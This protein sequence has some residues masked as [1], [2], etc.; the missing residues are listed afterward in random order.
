MN[1]DTYNLTNP[2]KSIWLTEEFFKGT[3][4][5][6]ISGNVLINEKVNFN[7]LEKAINIYV[8]KNE[9]IRTQITTNNQ[10]VKQYIKDY[11]YFSIPLVLLNTK[12][13]LNTFNKEIV[14]PIFSVIDS[15]LF[16][17]TLIKFKD[18]SGGLNVTFHHLI[19]DAW[20]MSLFIDE[21]MELYKNLLDKDTISY[22]LNPTYLDYIQSE[23]NYIKS[24]RYKKDANFWEET[25]S[26]EPEFAPIMNYSKNS[27]KTVEAS[28]KTF[29]LNSTLYSKLLSYCKNKNLSIY[30][31][32]MS[33][34]SIYLSKINNIKEP[35]I[36]TPILNRSNFKEKNTAGMYISTIPFKVA[37]NSDYC[38]CDFLNDVNT[39][40]LSIFRHQKYPYSELLNRIKNKY[41]LKENLYDIVIS[42]QNARNNSNSFSIPYTTEWLFN[43]SI[44]D[45]LEIHIYDM[46]NTG[47]LNI[48]YDYQ[49]AKFTEEDIISIHERILN[50]IS[51]VL[52]T[53]EILIKD[54]EITTPKEKE[55]ILSVFNDTDFS[56]DKDQTLIE[57][58]EQ[59]VIKSPNKTALVFEGKS[60]SYKEVNEKAN[61]I[62]HLL[63]EHY[64]ESNQ[65]VAI[66]M[67]RS[68]FIV[69]SMI[70]ILKA[71]AAYTLI[72]PT[73]P[74]KRIEYML[75][76]ADVKA[77]LTNSSN[78]SN[79]YPGTIFLDQIVL[80]SYSTNNLEEK[81]SN[82]DNLSI[83]YTSG[84]TGIPKGVLLRRL[85]M[86][87]LF[88][89][90]YTSMNLENLDNF[91][92]ICSISFDM[93]AVEVW[94]PLLGGKTLVFANSEE[95]KNPIFMKK[96]I[97][98]NKIEFMLITSSKMDLLLTNNDTLKSVKAIQLGGEVLNP[99]FYEKVTKYTDARI[100]NGY[101]PTEATACTTTKEITDSNHINIGKPLCNTKVYICNNDINLCPIGIPGELLIGG[102]GVAKRYINNSEVTS[103]CFIK[104]PFGEGMLY[105]SGDIGFYNKDGEIEY[106]GRNDFQVKINGQRIELEEI[107]NVLKQIDGI[108][109]SITVIKE[110]NSISTICSYYVCEREINPEII[111]AILSKSLP[112]YMVPSH[113]ICLEKMPL[114][115][116][117]K[118]DR[119]ALPEIKITEEYIAPITDTEK[120]LCTIWEKLLSKSPISINSNFFTIGGDS[121]SAIRMLTQI[122]NVF[123][124]KI[125][126]KDIFE[127][128][129]IKSLAS[130]IDKSDSTVNNNISISKAE[131]MDYY[132]LSSAQKRIY[133]SSS[134]SGENSTV[135]NTPMIIRLDGNINVKKIEH[136]FKYLIERHI[137]LRTYFDI[138]NSGEVIQK[139]QDK[140]NFSLSIEDGKNRSIYSIFN[141]FIK[142]FSM[143][144]APLMH[145]KLIKFSKKLNYIFIDLHHSICDGSSVS[146]LIKELSD[147][148]SNI[149]LTEEKINYIDF[150]VWEN[151]C[152]NNN[153]FL[154]SKNFWK[155]ELSGDL[156][157]LS[158]PTSFKRPEN[159][160]FKGD[161]LFF[162]I[163][164][165]KTQ[166]IKN[167]AIK[168]NTTP[169]IILLA[170]YYILLYK[171]SG[172]EDII[173]A[174]PVSGRYR[175]ELKNVLGMFVNSIPIRESISGNLTVK[176]FIMNLSNHFLDCI[177]HQEYPFDEMVKDLN[178]KRDTSRNPIFDTMFVYQNDGIPNL[179]FNNVQASIVNFPNNISKFDISLEII[180][181]ENTFS[182]SF[183]YA[184]SLF[185][186]EFI[187]HFSKHYQVI[188]SYVLEDISSNISSVP[189]I[190]SIEKKK[191]LAFNSTEKNYSKEETIE[192]IF[193]NIVEKNPNAPA[194]IYENTSISY[195]KLNKLSNKVA[196]FLISKKLNN[197]VIGILANRSPKLQIFMLG[198][199]KSG[200]SY[201]LIDPSL[202]KDRIEYMLT[203][204]KS[205]FCFVEENV[206]KID[207]E[208]IYMNNNTINLCSDVN[209]IST[210][211]NNDIFCVIYTSGSTG[212]P[213][214]VALKRQGI[215]NMLLSYKTILHTDDC[216]NF[217]SISAVSFDMFIVE[218][219]IPL[220]SGKTVIL[221]NEEEQKIP[222]YMSELIL[223][224]NVDFLLTTPSRIE[225]LLS[226]QTR[227]CLNNLKIIQLGGEVFT[228]TLYKS[229]REYTHS[230][231]YNGYG[232]SEITACC[233]SKEVTSAEDISIG[234]PFCNTK[235]YICNKDK[236]ICPIG[237]EG[238]ICVAGD[239]VSLGYFNNDE[240]TK[241]AFIP[242]PFGEGT[243]YCTGDIGKLNNK[244]EL[245]YI[246][247]NDFQI[248]IRG[249]RVEL[250][251]IEKKLLEIPEITNT[252]VIYVKNVSNP[253]IAAF[254][255]SSDPL[256]TTY[257]RNTLS[258]SLPL[259]M[260]PK[261]I[262]PLSSFPITSNGKVDKKSLANYNFDLEEKRIY[263]APQTETQKIMCDVW[264]KLLNTQVGIDDDIFELGADSLLAIKF[265]V[266]LLSN[267][268]NITYGDI[269][270]YRTVRLL[271]DNSKNS[272]SENMDTKDFSQIDT[273][274]EKNNARYINK[275][276]ICTNNNVLLLGSNG[277]V[278]MHILDSLLK[279]D[280]GN[281]YCIVR[282]KDGIK[283]EKRFLDILHF[284]FGSKWDF[285]LNRRI[286][287]ISGSIV[288]DNFGLER[289]VYENLANKI[290]IVINAAA[291]VKHYGNI[292]KFKK[293]NVD[294]TSKIVDFCN[295]FKKRLF[296]ISSLSV[297]GNMSLDG[298]YTS[299]ND[300]DGEKV[301]FSE[302]NLYIGQKLNN[303]YIKSKFEAEKIILKNIIE[304]GLESQIFRL[305]NITS[306]FSDGV[307]QINHTENA[308][309]NRI[310]SLSK[311]H[312][313]PNY[314]LDSYI[315]F[316]PVDCCAEAI[317]TLIQNY[318][319][320]FSVFHIYDSN[321]LLIK[322][323]VEF[324]NENNIN[325]NVL[326]DSEFEK[327]VDKILQ[328]SNKD[329]LSGII[330]DF[331]PNKKL[332][333]TSDIHILSEFTRAVL[334][335]LGFKWPEID[336]TYIKKYISYLQSINYI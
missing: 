113:F 62:A 152:L 45:S 28:R 180:P 242:N 127:F 187:E 135:Y 300:I 241:K 148:Y 12:D 4:I 49:N 23:E 125:L 72:L 190:S 52:N 174:S 32:L 268:I 263:V 320:E 333:Y 233:S 267:N 176:D 8:Q 298:D 260:V 71:G 47:N 225:L 74:Q 119:K 256:L 18:G 97:I 171:Y 331:G 325:L 73:L 19:A 258:S 245:E 295:K 335:S 24:E 80:S 16:R 142:P 54:I 21:V 270:K 264:Q 183:E 216:N 317:V 321:H 288:S 307:F 249:L 200:S 289:T 138:T 159:R 106:I 5:N 185:T 6:N 240:L 75:R 232:P 85:G 330:N 214:G 273:L 123:N 116:N 140:I 30:T 157:I 255:I 274:L 14:K 25:Y 293:I 201:L 86:L 69:F 269:F 266:E 259:Y 227:N 198:I 230:R 193:Y 33:I 247:R 108:R 58:F 239:G 254:Y 276:T 42:Y 51:S 282:D 203:N 40:Q 67:E 283:A 132:P 126:V 211:N 223:K 10:E 34:Y 297:S 66:I 43:Q 302:K 207:Y 13:D 15:N 237:L 195:D 246:G 109:N 59:N 169:Y 99:A 156:P 145:V 324:L 248:K 130:F 110:I 81:G 146:M 3:N 196:N 162:A 103:K 294:S 234:K 212:N 265:K 301:N 272:Y 98:D 161:R 38:F 133:Y 182:A 215:V 129:T 305:G 82:E 228:K 253:F 285:Y 79:C 177:E 199:L 50:M 299:R 314:L 252:A 178:L 222:T 46:D 151:Y 318:N 117:G 128:N 154:E 124:T 166:E 192:N 322:D 257:I 281:I 120:K 236:N 70:G 26:K 77:I 153:V 181:K 284:Y 310:K 316:T 149:S 336:R 134:I 17:F 172:Q 55:Q 170:C 229:L 309:L 323:F 278:G 326:T 9:A 27:P 219:F 206:Q 164:K 36:G 173:V 205:P 60:Y 114:T 218:N 184:T 160:D 163:G 243:L 57:K 189:I 29:T 91:L 65:V 137:T 235:I 204:A 2:Q 291:I 7:L 197:R 136:C 89:L 280:N 41:N 271:A 102:I 83:M 111:K 213:K 303:D 131:K 217:L 121:L 37:I 35:I 209:A 44:A 122:E 1:S 334:Y 175:E 11:S 311:I 312:A 105:R 165:M 115:A 210:S 20:T 313:I 96:L 244:G 332:V 308:F 287:V 84:S 328:N 202:P 64:I 76:T 95:E 304:H 250:S 327:L 92:S 141:D 220:L 167:L 296:H 87:N 179:S 56:F 139:T 88:Y 158:L 221:S 94:L 104:D 143:N 262:I 150:S 306:R 31:F 144:V 112:Y 315:E 292:E 118:I 275:N 277:F 48:Y 39:T 155:N 290:D 101:G 191:I 261:Y 279:K 226:S 61:Q 319:K 63:K 194:I 286:F 329:I 90:Y 251:E 208:T 224:E 231:I 168:L 107:N 93:F 238:E 68:P 147:I 188:L 78:L 100:F 186:K 22:D 53:P